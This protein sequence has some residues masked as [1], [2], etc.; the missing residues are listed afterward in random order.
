MRSFAGDVPVELHAGSPAIP[1][2]A[3][4]GLRIDDVL[5]GDSLGRRDVEEAGGA[6]GAFGDGRVDLIAQ[7]V[8]EGEAG[9]D[10]PSVLHVE[11]DVVAAD[12]GRADVG[13]IGEVRWGD[14][15]GVA[16]GVSD[17]KAAE[18]VG[19]GIAGVH[20]VR[21]V[22]GRN[23]DWRVDGSSA[24]V[25]FAVGTDAEVGGVAIEAG[26]YA[27]LNDVAA[28]CPGEVL[29]ALEEVS[30][31]GHYGSGG[32]IEGFI[33]AVCKFQSRVSVVGSGKRWRG[34]RDAE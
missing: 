9:G 30:K 22:L 31:G 27:G 5:L 12:G 14:G 32:G 13:S 28:G 11:V 34:A 6:V 8:V 23:E 3:I 29:L 16:E 4:A 20:G 17:K 33:E 19:Q 21:A 15:D 26:F 18:R 2:G 24:E 25:V 1:A 10:F 7:S